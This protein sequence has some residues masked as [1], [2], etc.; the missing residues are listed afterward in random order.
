[1]R[2]PFTIVGIGE[3]LFDCFPDGR[4]L[5]GGAPFNFAVQANRIASRFGGRAV[6][7]TRIGKDDLGRKFAASIQAP[8][9][10]LQWDPVHPTGRVDVTLE[11]GEPRYQIA[12]NVAWDFIEYVPLEC[13]A[14]C[15][16]TL[17]Q[18]SPRSRESI[19]RF[20]TS[21]PARALRL[22]DINL[23]QHY[24]DFSLIEQGLNLANAVKLNEEEMRIVSDLFDMESPVEFLTRFPLR[25]VILTQG[26][27]GTTMY[28]REGI[29]RGEP[30]SFK[31]APNADSVGAGDA[32]AAAATV[33]LVCGWPAKNV[34]ALANT[35]GAWVASQPGAL[36]DLP[37]SIFS[38]APSLT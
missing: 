30:V 6:P 10:G 9:E 16:G 37:E 3:G 17:A 5:P 23:R 19:H 7:V 1:M 38:V 21:T 2:P 24:W 31:L 32:S 8:L 12:E 29:T 27:K 36:P 14:V 28:T 33:G 26:A 25:T 13:D 15:F 4:Q 20:V 18:R 35:I 22:F 11:R 34:V